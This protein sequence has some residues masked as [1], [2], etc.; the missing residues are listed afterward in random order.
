MCWQFVSANNQ[1][2]PRIYSLI[3]QLADGRFHS[4]ESLG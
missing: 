4:G 2:T 1:M 3:E